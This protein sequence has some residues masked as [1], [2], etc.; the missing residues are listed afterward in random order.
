MDKAEIIVRKYRGEI[1]ESQFRGHI[2]VVNKS[3]K[4]IKSIGD[5]NHFTFIRSASK[6]FQAIALITS[7][8]FGSF[9]LS[10]KHLAVASGSHN[11]QK[12][13]TD[14]VFEMLNKASLSENNLL[15]GIHPP[16]TK[17]AKDEIGDNT[18]PVNNNCSG[19]HAAMLLICVHMGWEIQNYMNPEHPVQKLMKETVSKMCQINSNKVKIG[20]DGCGVPVFAMPLVNMAI[21]FSN[22][23]NKENLPEEYNKPVEAIV[24]AIHKYPDIYAGDDRIATAFVRDNPD[25]I[26]KAGAE[27]V[28]CFGLKDVGI[29]FKLE[30]GDDGK[31]SHFVI[32]NIAKKMG[33]KTTRLEKWWNPDIY[34]HS[35]TKVGEMRFN[36]DVWG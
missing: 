31:I 1:V 13:N 33:C 22:L 34:S 26:F 10:K 16:F 2:V 29:A 12:I 28:G 35:G 36:D 7:G 20:I 23:I 18:T 4:I 21:G 9:G 19:K 25:S 24:S 17:N 14:V 5:P 6:P 11:G 27:G 3:G 8:A 32:S 30:C 15:C